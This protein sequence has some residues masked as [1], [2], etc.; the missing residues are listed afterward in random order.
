MTRVTSAWVVVTLIVAMGVPSLSQATG[1]LAEPAD[2]ELHLVAG[3]LSKLD[4]SNGKGLLTTD[5]GRPIYF[6]VSKVYLFENVTVG[7]RIA[8][9]LDR[10]GHAV[11]VMDASIPDV[12]PQRSPTA[13]Q[14]PA[15]PFSA[16]GTEE[17]GTEGP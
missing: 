12:V 15:E 7:A 2:A 5:L 11:R 16:D 3:T 8:M 14:L 4:L 9:R 10:Y 17:K 6:D 1:D 13:E